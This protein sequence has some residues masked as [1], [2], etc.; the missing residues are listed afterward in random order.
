MRS[1]AHQWLTYPVPLMAPVYSPKP[2]RV[3][4]SL[5]ILHYKCL[6]PTQTLEHN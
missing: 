3:I 2:D 5:K 1:A 6:K 4:D